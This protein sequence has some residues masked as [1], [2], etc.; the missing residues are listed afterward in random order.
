MDAFIQEDKEIKILEVEARVTS[1]DLRRSMYYHRHSAYH[2][3]HLQ[4]IL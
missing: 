3:Q 1:G 4:T 2:L